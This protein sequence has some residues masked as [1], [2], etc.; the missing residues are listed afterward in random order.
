MLLSV[1]NVEKVEDRADDQ[2]GSKIIV[3]PFDGAALKEFVDSRYAG[4]LPESDTTA[5]TWQSERYN[6]YGGRTYLQ[7]QRQSGVEGIGES[8]SSGWWWPDWE[9]DCKIGF[10]KYDLPDTE[11]EVE[12]AY[13][14]LNYLGKKAG[15][16][17]TDR[18]RIV[19]ADPEWIEGTGIEED[20][21][22]EDLAGLNFPKLHYDASDLENTSVVSEEFAVNDGAKTVQV[23]V[24]K[25][26]REF[27]E[28]YPEEQY[29][30]FALNE[31]EAGNCLQFGSKEAGEGYG[32]RLVIN[33][34]EEASVQD[35][36]LKL[37]VGMA[38]KLERVQTESQCYTE[39][40]WMEVQSALDEARALL[41]DPDAAQQEVDDAFLKL[42]TVCNLLE[43]NVQ[44][45]GLKAVID[46]VKAILA[47]SGAPEQYTSESI[48]TVR[49]ALAYA[50]SVYTLEGADQTTVNGAATRLMSAA[51]CLLI[52]D[53]DSRLDIL[54]RKAEELLN[55]RDM[56]TDSSAKA[57]ETALAAAK[58]TAANPQAAPE[59]A[60]QAYE[61][62]AAAM[63]ALVRKADKSELKNALDK[64]NEILKNPAD[65]VADTIAG[66][67]ETTEKSQQI[68]EDQTADASSVGAAVKALV[69]EI[70]KARLKGDVNLDGTVDTADTAEVLQ[71]AAE[72]KELTEEQHKAADVNGD[73]VSDS[74]DA[75]GILQYASEKI[76]E[77]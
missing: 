30:S 53:R 43:S 34:K 69:E 33:Y 61:V 38:E 27:K 42:M 26:V 15:D 41:E 23:D 16:A 56:Y 75:S 54:I 47:D 77:F 65:Y 32:A 4:T 8:G 17:E 20:T 70:L 12:S 36:A 19:L 10:L 24:T 71:Y 66:L 68:Y 55:N 62:L 22:E 72:Y 11:R 59:E 58:D 14:S 13:L 49:D 45:V 64:A 37:A 51:N 52:E 2:N 50:E 5:Q 29:I 35:G 18:V 44:R 40:S 31:T 7:I 3:T 46:G 25:L 60:E 76:T 39:A 21:Q 28:N 6:N 1:I 57:L 48:Q 63:T 74:S 67:A 9:Y 73:G